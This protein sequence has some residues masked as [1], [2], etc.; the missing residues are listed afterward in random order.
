MI[1]VSTAEALAKL[2]IENGRVLCYISNRV[3][4][5]AICFHLRD[6]R[7]ARTYGYSDH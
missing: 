7:Q 5:S 4:I 6:I 2:G 3:L 1:V